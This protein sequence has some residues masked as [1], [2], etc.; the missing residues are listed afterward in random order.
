MYDP[1]VEEY[2]CCI[3]NVVEGPQRRVKIVVVV[4][5]DCLDPSLDFL[6]CNGV[7]LEA[8]G[9]ELVLSLT[10]FSDIAVDTILDWNQLFV[11]SCCK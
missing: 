4:E 7:S 2:L 8:R 3:R 5:A 9:K 11:E 1:T 6:Y 10:C